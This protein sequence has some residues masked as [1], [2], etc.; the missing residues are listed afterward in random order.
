METKFY[1]I[2]GARRCGKDTFV[3]ILKSLDA[4]VKRVAFADALKNDLAQLFDEKFNVNIHTMEGE[5][6]EI[7]RPI[8]ISYGCS[9]RDLDPLHWVKVVDSKIQKTIDNGYIYCPVDFRFANEIKFFKDKYGDNFK[10]ISIHRNGG[11]EPTE[12]EKRNMP[13]IEPFID[14]ELTW[15]TDPS[16]VSIVPQVKYFYEEHI[17]GLI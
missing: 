4:R 7:L 10:L 15:D 12:E 14:F 13:E 2:T 5:I 6:K 8:L 1:G 9:W 17:L 11:P 3:S 16:L